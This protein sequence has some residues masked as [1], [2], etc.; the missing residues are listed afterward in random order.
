MFVCYYY[1][2]LKYEEY[3][4]LLGPPPNQTSF[5]YNTNIWPGVGDLIRSIGSIRIITFDLKEFNDVDCKNDDDD[6]IDGA[7]SIGNGEGISSRFEL[8]DDNGDELLESNVTRQRIGFCWWRI[9]NWHS[10]W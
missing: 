4:N 2:Y 10:N 5:W 7:S 8:D 1:P 9:W 3:V 6:W